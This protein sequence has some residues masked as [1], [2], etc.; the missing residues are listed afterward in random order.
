M[1]T[2]AKRPDAMHRFGLG[3]RP[4]PREPK[5]TPKLDPD[6]PMLSTIPEAARQLGLSTRTLERMIA[7]GK[8][9]TV[10]VGR[11]RRIRTRDLIAIAEHGLA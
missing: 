1:T 7:E 6:Q 10:K 4:A 2:P 8:I 9:D 3:P 5:P 11:S